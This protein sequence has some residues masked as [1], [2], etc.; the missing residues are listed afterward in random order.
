MEDN[1]VL[2]F[3]SDKPWQAEIAKQVLSDN[4]IEAVIINKQDSSYHSFGDAEVYVPKESFEKSK[5][6]I[7]T[8]E[9]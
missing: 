6:I 8:I 9:H 2:V 7:N 3:S 1:W 4:G 5:E